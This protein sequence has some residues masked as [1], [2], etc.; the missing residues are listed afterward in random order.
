MWNVIVN[1]GGWA[2]LAAVIYLLLGVER[3]PDRKRELLGNGLFGNGKESWW[4]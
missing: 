4:D 2:L 1:V 3:W